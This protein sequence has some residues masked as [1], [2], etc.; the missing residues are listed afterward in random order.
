MVMSPA[1]NNALSGNVLEA[2][3][4][5]PRLS[6][7]GNMLKNGTSGGPAVGGWGEA[8]AKALTAG[9]G[10]YEIGQLQREYSAR[11]GSRNNAVADAL[12]SP[13]LA[14]LTSKFA[15]NPDTADLQDALM[16]GR[17]E[18]LLKA[19][20]PITPFQQQQLDR[21]QVV[22]PFGNMGPKYR[23]VGTQDP[24]SVPASGTQTPPAGTMLPPPTMGNP[25]A[26]P[27]AAALNGPQQAPAVGTAM[28]MSPKG[29]VAGQEQAG[30][31]LAS[32]A[33][34]EAANDNVPKMANT[35]TMIN[36]ALKLNNS[37]P[38]GM[39]Q[40]PAT[41]MLGRLTN[42]A[43]L[44][45]N[46]TKGRDAFTKLAAFGSAIKAEMLKPTVGGNQISN[47][48][49]NFVGSASSF[50]PKMSTKER[51]ARLVQMREITQRKSDIEALEQ[52]A[53][54]QGRQFTPAD[55]AAYYQSKGLPYEPPPGVQMPQTPAAT[56]QAQ[57][58]SPY[59]K[60]SDDQ[61]RQLLRG[62]R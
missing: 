61:L 21:E 3:K 4:L 27:V 10:G 37:A 35:L 11:Q 46:Q 7:A 45:D 6:L 31:N 51:E 5:D 40:G 32:R 42:D 24:N 25:G 8:V 13:D 50:D 18:S 47:A 62:G 43:Y 26:T 59:A 22:D 53:A 23:P 19:N 14:S 49:V 29:I 55:V 44:T 33:I 41:Q 2:Y 30:K 58:P 60:M 48:D 16:K 15:G 17:Q 20:T 52:Q 56:P 36:D 1:L 39:I 28:P 9:M 38:G 12:N 54:T 34:P 57:G